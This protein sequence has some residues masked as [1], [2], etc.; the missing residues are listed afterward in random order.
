M[1]ICICDEKTKMLLLSGLII[2]FKKTAKIECNLPLIN[3]VLVKKI[4]NSYFKANIC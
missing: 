4:L 2:N 1:P 3:N